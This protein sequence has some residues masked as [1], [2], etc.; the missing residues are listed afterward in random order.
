MNQEHL[1]SVDKEKKQAILVNAIGHCM[2]DKGI[3]LEILDNAYR[4][5]QIWHRKNALIPKCGKV[6]EGINGTSSLEK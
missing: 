3:T 1:D 5:I 2:A 6:F 4:E